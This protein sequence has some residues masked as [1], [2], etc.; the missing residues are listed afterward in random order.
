MINETGQQP[1]A[2]APFAPRPFVGKVGFSHLRTG[3]TIAAAVLLIAG[4][5]W[6]AASNLNAV[7]Q[8]DRLS[9]QTYRARVLSKTLLSTLTDAETGQRGYLLT[10]NVAYLTP[11][12]TARARLSAEF[13]ALRAEPQMLGARA[14]P[15]QAVQALA[16]A[17]LA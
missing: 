10:G 4:S 11:Y 3:A 1:D 9:E 7:R 6:L 8:A 12:T 5:L 16:K 14:E 17:K 15:L 2:D 13:A